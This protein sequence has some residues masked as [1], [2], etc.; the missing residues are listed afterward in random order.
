[1]KLAAN[2]ELSIPGARMTGFTK[3]FLFVVLSL[4]QYYQGVG[5]TIV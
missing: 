5:N 2:A 1:M 4:L 3:D